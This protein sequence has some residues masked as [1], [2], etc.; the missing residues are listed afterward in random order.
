[1][2][3]SRLLKNRVWEVIAIIAVV[4]CGFTLLFV[5]FVERDLPIPG[6]PVSGDAL[7]EELELCGYFP[8]LLWRHPFSS[9]VHLN[10]PRLCYNLSRI[11]GLVNLTMEES[12]IKY[13]SHYDPRVM[14]ILSRPYGFKEKCLSV[15]LEI[16]SR[17]LFYPYVEVRIGLTTRP[18]GVDESVLDSMGYN[19]SYI[20]R[21]YDGTNYVRSEWTK[22]NK[23]QI[24][25]SDYSTWT[26]DWTIPEKVYVYFYWEENGEVYYSYPGLFRALVRNETTLSEDLVGEFRSILEAHGFDSGLWEEANVTV[27]TE[28]PKEGPIHIPTV[29]ILPKE[30]DWKEAMRVELE[31]LKNNGI[32]LNLSE[33][34]IQSI[35]S[36]CDLGTSSPNHRIIFHNGKWKQYYE[37]VR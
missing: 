17:P 28:A 31:W 8:H 22:G 30:F 34:D 25:V 9:E 21:I 24:D 10:R 32:I 15:G 16:P 20:S 29:S 2:G 35:S 1:M 27:M 3:V 36:L 6:G 7:W 14:V 26:D 4:C 23:T 33:W 19:G 13:E 18:E 12:A 37:I 5:G 11:E